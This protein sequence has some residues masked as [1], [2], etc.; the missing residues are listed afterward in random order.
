MDER[1]NLMKHDT[2]GDNRTRRFFRA[3]TA[4]RE[5]RRGKNP[6]V[7]NSKDPCTTGCVVP[8][9]GIDL[10][11][12]ENLELRAGIRSVCSTGSLPF[13]FPFWPFFISLRTKPQRVYTRSSGWVLG[14]RIFDSCSETAVRGTGNGISPNLPYLLI[15]L[16]RVG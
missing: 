13:L 12:C 15:R 2:R 11:G 10:D 4:K 9:I 14:R 1:R 8:N 7:I 6:T 5:K 3:Y 16:I